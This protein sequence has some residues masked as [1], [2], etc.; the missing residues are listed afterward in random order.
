VPVAGG[1]GVA[2]LDHAVRLIHGV[3]CLAGSPAFVDDC[4]AE[5]THTGVLAAIAGHDTAMLFDWLMAAVSYQGVS[6]HAATTYMRRH[7]RVR[8]HDIAGKLGRGVSCPKLATYW[9]YHGCRYD[10]TSRTCA[11]PDHLPGC[12]VPSHRLRNGRLNQTAYSLHLFVRD[13]ASGDLVAWINRRLTDAV[14]ADP[15]DRLAVSRQA[16][17]S[18]LRNVY[19]VSDK[20]L[21]MALATL[22]IGA[23]AD[24]PGWLEVGAGMVAI[25]SLVHAFLHR[26]AAAVRGRPWL[27]ARLLPAGRMRRN[28]RDGLAADRCARV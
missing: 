16:L 26:R 21:A 13:I 8:W 6:D 9:H 10:K 18:P 23:A 3:C 22:L 1:P 11:E 24:R 20:V 12:P 17:L 7:G 4:R 5:L 19:G 2:A 14:S 28:R 25:D 27:R 15:V